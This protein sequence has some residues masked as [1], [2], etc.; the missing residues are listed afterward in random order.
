MFGSVIT[1][2]GV[3]T[4]NYVDFRGSLYGSG[5]FVGITF[6]NF[7]NS[8]TGY[9]TCRSRNSASDKTVVIASK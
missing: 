5:D 7:L 4:S 1:T 8:N 9:Y 3:S 2:I 6:Y